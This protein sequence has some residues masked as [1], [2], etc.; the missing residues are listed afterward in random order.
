MVVVFVVVGGVDVDVVVVV[1]VLEV[2]LLALEASCAGIRCEMCLWMEEETT[3]GL[4]AGRSIKYWA[5][6]RRPAIITDGLLSLG[7]T[8]LISVHVGWYEHLDFEDKACVGK[9]V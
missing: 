5:T 1:V 9:Q 3:I 2:M 6:A 4:G 7:R 8:S